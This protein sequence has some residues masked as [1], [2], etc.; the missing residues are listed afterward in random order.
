MIHSSNGGAISLECEF[1]QV[2]KQT[3]V[4]QITGSSIKQPQVFVDPIQ[5]NSYKGLKFGSKI[6]NN[7]F[8]GNEV[9]QKGSAIYMRQ[10]SIALIEQ[11]QFIKNQ[12]GY[13][14]RQDIKRPYD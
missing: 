4:S 2:V 9:G 6:Y 5:Y 8:E 7:L 14:F 13:S 1:V 3:P 10:I 11:N 12:P